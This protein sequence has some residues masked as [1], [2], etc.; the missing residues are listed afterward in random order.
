M[1]NSGPLIGFNTIPLLREK[2]YIVLDTRLDGDAPKQLIK[3]YEYT[4]GGK[5][6]RDSLKSWIRYI[7]KTGEKWYPHESVLE[8][9][10]NR[11]G[12]ELGISMNEIKLY[13]INGQ[14]RFLSRFFLSKGEV[15]IHGAEICGDYLEDREFAAQIANDKREAR[16]LF[17]FEFI[18]EA[19][20]GMFGSAGRRILNQ[21]V[22]MLIFDALVGNNDRHFYNWAVI[23]PARKSAGLPRLAPIY[24]S[25]RGFFWN[26]SEES[27]VKWCGLVDQV[28]FAK[29][30]RY[31]NRACPRFSVEDDKEIN[32]FDF[33][34]YLISLEPRYAEYVKVLAGKEN[35]AKLRTLLAAEFGHLFSSER[36]Y[37]MAKTIGDRFER[38]RN[39]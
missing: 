33:V 21:L 10:I 37:L 29:Y 8:Y 34:A 31:L 3:L 28:G 1:N 25:S 30:E 7:A 24:D 39:L 9:F 27:V 38:V 26:Q 5:M 18:A 16:E 2:D 36:V 35:E 14:V 32:H 11:C 12:Q 13:R 17:T 20:S 23:R 22:K 15:L 19:I 4:A 6:R